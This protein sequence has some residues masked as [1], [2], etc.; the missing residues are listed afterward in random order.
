MTHDL[1]ATPQTVPPVPPDAS[2]LRLRA[3]ARAIDAVEEVG[4]VLAAELDLGRLVQ[5]VTDASTRLTEAEFGAFFY[6]VANA[7]GESYSLY[8]LSGAPREAFAGFPMPRNT[9]IFGPTFRGEGTVRIADVQKDPRYGKLAPHHGMPP[10]H[11]PVRSY[12]AAPVVSRSGEVLGGL[13]FGH[14]EAGRFTEDHEHLLRGIAQY[15]AIALDNARLYERARVGELAN[16]R[17][18]AIIQ[19]SDDAIVSKDL[20]GIVQSWNPGAT[21]MFGFTAE[22]MIGS[23]ITKLFPPDRTDEETAILAR[24]RRGERVDHFETVRRTKDGRLLDV[25]VSI[26]PIRDATGQVVGASKVARDITERKRAE[27]EREQLLSAERAARAEAERHSR[28]K[29]EFL[30]TLGHELRTPLNAVLGWASL[31]KGH[32]PDPEAIAHGLEV[33]E[34]NARLQ[35]QLIEDLLDM[36]RIVSGKLRLSVQQVELPSVIHSALESVRPASEAKGVRLQHVMDARAGSVSGDPARLQQVVWNL[37]SN[38][39]KFTPRGGRVQ[40]VLQRV[41]SHVELSV[42]DTGEGIAPEFLPLVFERFR[43]ADAS[44]TRQHGG[45]G[46]GLAIVKHLVELHGGTV[47]A[48]SP[49]PG[50]GATFTVMLPIRAMHAEEPAQ[51]APVES[52]PASVADISLEG[53][54]I[55]VVDD[56]PDARDLVRRVLEDA[57]AEVRTASG[58]AAG[59]EL[60]RECPPDVLIS[61]IGM[62]GEDGYSLLRRVRGL[63]PE[64]GGAVPAVALT[65]FARAD[66]RRRALLSGFQM[67]V[68]K[69]VEAPELLAVVASVTKRV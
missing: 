4:R 14:S 24:L 25:S 7:E 69:P 11:L 49:G 22:E 57:G 18:A 2:D 8:T 6:N 40:V 42:S 10:G 36:S 34:R 35:A 33:I 38:A 64:G 56:E 17:L 44:T 41:N 20:N 30:A 29:D 19:S 21:R 15:A 39:V 9:A 55:V 59:F 47:A 52:A 66:D 58:A 5:V 63:P 28:M 45:L 16:A 27:S 62:P 23:S 32:E 46:L 37:L 26:S 68:P 65:A 48:R 43:Q 31:L 53:L 50:Q 61:D 60:I 51:G 67:H 12:L 1:S 13:F 54:R 3:R